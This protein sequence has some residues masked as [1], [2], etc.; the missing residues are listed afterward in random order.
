MEI[1]YFQHKQGINEVKHYRSGSNRNP[2]RA[3][4]VLAPHLP[5]LLGHLH[6]LTA[7]LMG[8]LAG[9][10]LV[11]VLSVLVFS[12]ITLTRTQ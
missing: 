4:H 12:V 6:T 5:D 11:I 7:S 3:K 10:L 8:Q 2:D 9:L 1:H